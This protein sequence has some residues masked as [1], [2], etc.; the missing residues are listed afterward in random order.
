LSVTTSATPNELLLD[1]SSRL[2]DSPTGNSAPR[3]R[4][5]HTKSRLGCITCKRRKIKVG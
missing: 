3:K 2:G 4:R 1:R 5:G